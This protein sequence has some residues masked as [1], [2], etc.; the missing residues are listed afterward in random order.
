MIVMRL[1]SLLILIF[2]SVFASLVCISFGS[3]S[4]SWSELFTAIR[5]GE[6]VIWDVLFRLRL[7]RVVTAFVAGALLSVAGCFIQTL[8]RNPLAD[9]YIFG[10]SSGA[11]IGVLS[12]VFFSLTVSQTV[13][14][15]IGAG[16][17]MFVVVFLSRRG[18]DWN[19]YRL[20][21][22]GVMVS[23]GLNA[24]ISLGLI[25][26]PALA[27]KGMLFWLMGDLT[28][29]EPSLFAVSLLVILVCVSWFLGTSL[30]ALTLG[31]ERAIT[32]GVPVITLEYF[33]YFGAAIATAVVVV[34]A[35]A[36]GFVGLVVPHIVRLLGGW[37]YRHLIILSASFGGLLVVFA[38]TLARTV[39]APVQLPVGVF[40]A[41]LGVPVLIA[42]LG[43]QSNVRA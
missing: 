4:I 29:A 38:D 5:T 14:G 7:P 27:I 12:A 18:S 15:F 22:T 39:W 25:L 42:L 43:R 17:V 36:I 33:L 2:L 6:G 28:Y 10:V 31:R 26:S 3:V 34:D 11:A 9:P 21:L 19:P 41:L 16:L 24:A 32:L 13:L 8:V 1:P 30:D 20:I 40:T 37:R 23:A 35:G